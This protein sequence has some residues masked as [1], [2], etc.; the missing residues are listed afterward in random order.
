MESNMSSL[1]KNK[2]IYYL[3]LY[4][5][6]KRV[7]KSLKS[8]EYK[9]AKA[10]KPLMEASIIQELTGIKERNAELSFPQLVNRFLKANHP[11]SQSTRDLN[12]YILKSYLKKKPLPSNPSSRATHIRHINQCWKWGVKNKLVRK[13]ELIKGDTKGESRLR[14]YTEKE[15]KLLFSEINDE[16]FNSFIRFAYY[17]GA[18]SGEIRSISRDLI[19]NECIYKNRTQNGQIKQSGQR[20]NS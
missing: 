12:T 19:L 16:K 1:Y 8:S 15:L 5:N 4:H 14:T 18:R 13:A 3:S 17:T 6:G 10:L 20:Y 7:T 11:W 2:N 9:V